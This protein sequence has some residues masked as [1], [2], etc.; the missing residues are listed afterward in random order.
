M[1]R[2]VGIAR[3]P[4]VFV[5]LQKYIPSVNWFA[6]GISNVALSDSLE[7]KERHL[8]MVK[9]HENKI[10]GQTE[11]AFVKKCLSCNPTHSISISEDD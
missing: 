10:Q 9:E 4:A 6:L 7:K 8:K 2:K 11:Q 5:A 3:E 1:S